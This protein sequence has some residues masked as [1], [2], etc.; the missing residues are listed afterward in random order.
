MPL[1]SLKKCP[2]FYPALSADMKHQTTFKV[3]MSLRK[4]YF[5]CMG[6]KVQNATYRTEKMALAAKLS[7]FL[8]KGEK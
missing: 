4:P 3:N 6:C 1:E 8:I 7:K 2:Q 5:L